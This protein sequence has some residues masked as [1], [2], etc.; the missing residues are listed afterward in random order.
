MEQHIP[1]NSVEDLILKH[2]KIWVDLKS[3]KNEA[4]LDEYEELKQYYL[5]ISMK[6]TVIG[7]G[8]GTFN[9]LYGLKTMTTDHDLDLAAIIA[10]TDSG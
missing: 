1:E 3:K 10:M 9:V 6:I 4:H 8:S 2:Q 7:G 5:R